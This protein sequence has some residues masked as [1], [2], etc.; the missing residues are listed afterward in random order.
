MSRLLTPQAGRVLLD[1]KD[2][3]RLPTKEVARTLGLLPQSPIAPEG[4]VVGDLVAAAGTR[5]SGC[6]RAGRPRT[7]TRSPRRSR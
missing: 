2:L 7:T 6:W 1:G 3:H 4:I 5:T